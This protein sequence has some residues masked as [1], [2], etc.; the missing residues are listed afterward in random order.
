MAYRI[1]PPSYVAEI[2]LA[3]LPRE[4]K[5]AEFDATRAVLPP[6]TDIEELERDIGGP[7]VPDERFE[8][9]PAG[10]LKEIECLRTENEQLRTENERLRR[11]RNTHRR[12]LRRL[13]AA[14]RVLWGAFVIAAGRKLIPT[15]HSKQLDAALAALPKEKSDE[16]SS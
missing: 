8:V 15:G 4:T 6:E 10:R 9:H 14:H 16:R 7:L 12:E 3:A 1:E 5:M 2:V 13:N 11:L